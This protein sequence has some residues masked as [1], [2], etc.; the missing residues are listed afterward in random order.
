MKSMRLSVLL[1]AALLAS[2]GPVLADRGR[3]GD[4]PGS[5]QGSSLTPAQAG[6][7]ARRQTGGRVLGVTASDGGY[8][9]KVLTPK[10]EIRY[11]F[12]PAR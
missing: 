1:L 11:V 4:S 3:G 7:M 6:E 8:R 5:G 2:A 10:G 12:V 9:V